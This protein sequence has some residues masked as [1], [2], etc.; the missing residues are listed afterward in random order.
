MLAYSQ[1]MVKHTP[2][3]IYITTNLKHFQGAAFIGVYGIS[4]IK[5][6]NCRYYAPFVWNKNRR[7]LIA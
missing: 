4:C 3:L 7:V 5:T 2:L 6:Q 1:V